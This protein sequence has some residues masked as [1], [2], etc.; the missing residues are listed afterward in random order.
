MGLLE[1]DAD[2]I[3]AKLANW[4]PTNATTE[5][6]C[7]IQ[8]AALLHKLFPKDIFEA[9]YHLGTTRAD[10]RVHFHNYGAQVVVEVKYG[11]DSR[12]EYHRLIGQIWTYVEEWKHE[13][14][15]VLC[16]PCD[17]ALTRH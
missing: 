9:E 16:G 3:V 6:D 8:L 12:N 15:L 7:Q 14:V 1:V 11:L 17:E 5:K 10:L 4:A 2:D 13:V